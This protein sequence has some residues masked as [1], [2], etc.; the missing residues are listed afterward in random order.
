MAGE[1]RTVA[2][3]SK[4]RQEVRRRGQVAR[5]ME[6]TSIVVF[7]GVIVCLHA[8]GSRSLGLLQ[9][10]MRS[11]LGDLHRA[12]LSVHTPLMLF[13]RLGML[14]AAVIGPFLLTALVIGLAVNL[15]QTGAN[16]SVYPLKPNF[17]LLNPLTGL[18]RLFSTRSL[19]ETLKA[20]GKLTI[21]GY[22]AYRTIANGYPVLLA[23][24]RQDPLTSIS[25]IGDLLYQLATRIALFLL[26]LAAA[27]YGY[28][29]WS[30]EKSIRMTKKEVRDELKEQNA[31]PNVRARIRAR[32]RQAARGRMMS[33]VPKADVV[34]V[35]PTHYA[36]ALRYEPGAMMAPQ[37]VAKG[38]DLVAKR[39]REIAE[40]NRVPIV[41][42]P[43]LARALY[44]AVQVGREIPSE[45]YAAVAEVLAYVYQINRSR[46]GSYAAQ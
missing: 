29:R 27:D 10:F 46:A 3:T 18:Q 20:I 32:Q 14:L 21:I 45:H 19:F 11:T 43:P 31:D 34:I 8:F 4:K 33:E 24:S 12:D 30:F 23:T 13:T 22:I 1:D 42:N 26:V 37:V 40:E 7:L 35:N 25:V 9:D 15:A 41:E 39:I 16:V 2:A 36:V 5:S 17:T 44:R 38:A 6:L 28:Q